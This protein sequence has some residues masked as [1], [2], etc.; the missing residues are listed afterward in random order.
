MGRV[1]VQDQVEGVRF[2]AERPYVDG[3]RIAATVYG[4]SYGGYMTLRLLLLAPDVFK[5]GGYRGR[6]G[7]RLGGLRQPLYRALHVGHRSR[8]RTLPIRQVQCLPT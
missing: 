4:W 6:S 8:T 2:L 3:E 5:A 1:E 7:D